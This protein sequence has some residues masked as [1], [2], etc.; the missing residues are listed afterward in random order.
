MSEVQTKER[1]GVDSL[2]EVVMNF[3][4]DTIEDYD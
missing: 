3:E 4:S 2:P 1:L